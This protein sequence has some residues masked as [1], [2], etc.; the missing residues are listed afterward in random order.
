MLIEESYYDVKTSYG[1]TMRLFVYH[2]KILG[3]LNAK[4]PGVVVYS[5]I[6]QVCQRDK[7]KLH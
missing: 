1:T 2:P 4:F 7:V 6:Y 5:E 3:F